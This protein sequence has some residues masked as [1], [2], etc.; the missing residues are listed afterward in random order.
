VRHLDSV[1]SLFDDGLGHRAMDFREHPSGLL[2][3]GHFLTRHLSGAIL[4]RLII[5]EIVR[6]G[7]LPVGFGTGERK[8]GLSRTRFAF[9]LSTV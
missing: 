3:R 4:N 7:Y 1:F 5:D 2:N 9:A 6:L 8:E